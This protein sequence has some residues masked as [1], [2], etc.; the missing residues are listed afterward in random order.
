[1]FRSFLQAGFEC[2]R[3]EWQG[4]F[5]LLTGTHHL[6]EAR[7]AAHYAILRAHGIRTAR[8][9]LPPWLPIE[10]RL[11]VAREAD[12]EVIWDLNHYWRHADPEGY[13]RRVAEA[14]LAVA[15]AETFW[16][17]FNETSFHPRMVPG[18]STAFVV[19]QARRIL[20]ILRERLPRLRLVTSE[21]A[22][23]PHEIGA[24]ALA[25]TADVVGINVYPHD[26]RRS[27]ARSLRDVAAR[28][29]KP[30]MIAETGLHKGHPRRWRGIDDKGDWLRHVL[31]EVERSRAPVAGVCLYPIVDSPAWNAPH[32]HRW[33]HGLIHA[34]L[35]LDPSLSAAL[36]ERRAAP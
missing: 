16:C 34:D 3:L 27:I 13:A 18:E 12:M 20:A 9:G 2:G 31:A 25:D 11:R 1:M 7:M 14:V 24:H 4:N 23:R 8:D 32:R 22:H 15:P 26:L 36:L 30:V 35:T 5:C 17:C 19:E 28:Y 6:P 29:G 33:D 21:P 10:P